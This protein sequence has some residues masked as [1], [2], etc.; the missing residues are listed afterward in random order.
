MIT[1]V[2]GYRRTGKDTLYSMVNEGVKFNWIVYSNKFSEINMKKCVKISFSDTLR[3]EV[4]KLYKISKPHDYDNVKD[5]PICNG[6][7]YRDILIEHAALRLDQNKYYWVENAHDW[8]NNNINVM[9]CDF[10]YKHEYEY[11]EKSGND[12]MTI[13]LFRSEVEIPGKDVTSEHGLDD[14]LTD[15]LFVT[16]EEEFEKAV[17]IFPQYKNFVRIRQ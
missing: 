17:E 10:R 13:R 8:N 5:L 16:S 3:N 11:I 7:S 15:Y 6:R 4:E 12:I 9:V 2:C 14:F 1:L